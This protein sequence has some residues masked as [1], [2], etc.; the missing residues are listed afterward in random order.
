MAGKTLHP[1]NTDNT[2]F[3]AF[4]LY[5]TFDDYP[6]KERYLQLLCLRGSFKKA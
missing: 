1:L 3:R 2:R 4:S 5:G 6:L